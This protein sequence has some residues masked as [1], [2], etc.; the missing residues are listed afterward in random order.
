MA[1]FNSRHYKK[2]SEALKPLENSEH[3]ALTIKQLCFMFTEDNPRF[4][5]ILF[6]RACYVTPKLYEEN[7]LIPIDKHKGH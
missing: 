2:L 6:I 3:K 1:T 7:F 5:A 4:D